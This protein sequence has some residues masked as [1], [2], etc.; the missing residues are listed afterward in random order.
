MNNIASNDL[1]TAGWA[2]VIIYMAVIVFLVVRGAIKIKNMSDYAVGNIAF[3]PIAVGLALAASMTSA[4]TFIINPGFIAL[5]GISGVIS[6]AIVLP[7]AAMVSL[8]LLTKGFR[9]HGSTVK[10]LTMAQWMGTRYKSKAYSL[11]FAFLSLLLITFIVLIC[12]GL[13]KVL[14]KTLNVSEISILIGIVVFIFGYM[15]FGGANSMV[16]TNTVQAIIMLLV[17]FILLGSGYQNF[18]NGIH[19]FLDKLSSIDPKLIQTTNASSF[20]FRDYFEIIFAQI[21]IGTAIVCQPHIITK[22]LLLKTDKDVNKYLTSGIITQ[23]IF[24]LVVT[25]G[26]YARIAFPDLTVNGVPLKLDGIISAYVVK[27]FPV[28]VGLI[29][30]LGLISAGISTLEG[31]IQAVATTITTDIIEPLLGKTFPKDQLKYEQAKLIINK[32][33]II[34]LAVVSIIISYDQLLHPKLSVGIFAQNGVYAYFSAAFVPILFGMFL[35]NAPKESVI[36]ASLTAI[37]IHFIFYYGKVVVPFTKATGEN[38]G[39]AA[40]VAI[41]ASLIVGGIIYLSVR[42]KRNVQL[43]N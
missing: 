22:S 1:V 16:Y 43:S 31:L 3:S 32:A 15:M 41:C 37:I 18:S 8:V 30:V 20:L 7:I 25:V 39:V 33:V 4:A 17:A 10:A 28:Y 38:P 21:V 34:L 6:Y 35:K 23:M 19:G 12:V 40:T 36:A 5:Y 2:L 11:F 27:E 42:R 14:S 13:T 9:K 29:V 26:L 24:F